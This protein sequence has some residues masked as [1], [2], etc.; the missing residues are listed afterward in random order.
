MNV[1]KSEIM[2]GDHTVAYINGKCFVR[3]AAMGTGTMAVK[4]SPLIRFVS[5]PGP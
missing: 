3:K 2:T 1:F 5:P 4:V